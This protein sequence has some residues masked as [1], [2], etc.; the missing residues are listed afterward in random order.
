MARTTIRTE[1]ITAGEVTTAKLAVDPTDADNLSSGDVPLAQLGNVP[2]TDL[3]GI[4][5]DIALL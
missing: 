3:T 4:E 5:D 2:D 1:D